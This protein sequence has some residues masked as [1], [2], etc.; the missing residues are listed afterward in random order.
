MVKSHEMLYEWW[1]Y[2][3]IFYFEYLT[4]NV[5][6]NSSG[7]VDD[8]WNNLEQFKRLTFKYCLLLITQAN[9]TLSVRL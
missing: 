2:L 4:K 1:I 6:Y 3:I 7:R 9:N 5:S 8:G